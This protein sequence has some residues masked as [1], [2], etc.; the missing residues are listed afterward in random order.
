MIQ[1]LSIIVPAAALIFIA[2]IIVILIDK[3]HIHL[4]RRHLEEERQK[5]IVPLLNLTT[6]RKTLSLCL[7]NEGETLVRDISIKDVV[8]IVHVGFQKRIGIRFS[9]IERIKPHESVPLN[10]SIFDNGQA[11]P[12]GT[13][14]RMGGVFLSASFRVTLKCKNMEGIPFRIDI[15]KKGQDS[16]AVR[17]VPIRENQF[18]ASKKHKPL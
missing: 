2:L 5:R 8:T 10:F 4:L 14:K 6:D 12:P 13:I 15:A 16:K 9:P 18:R 11:I 3:K 1:H 7:A 17:I